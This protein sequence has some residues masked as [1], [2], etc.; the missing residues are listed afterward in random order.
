M[1][2]PI[3]E[4]MLAVSNSLAA[5]I[6]VK[7]TLIAALGLLGAWAA[8]SGRASVRHALLAASFGVLLALPLAAVFAP[9][10]R[11]AVTPAA[12]DR[13]LP[14]FAGATKAIPSAAA[15]PNG[16]AVKPAIRASQGLSPSAVLFM[17]WAAGTLLFLLP[18]MMGLWQVGALRRSALPWRHGQSLA[19]N[20]ARDAGIRRRVEVLLHESLPGPM[21]C[22]ILGPAIVLSQDAQ[23]WDEEDLNRAIVHE[24][25]HVRRGDW[26]ILC[27]ARAVCAAYWFHPLV[28]IAWRRL[29]LDAERACDDAVLGHSDAAAYADQLVGLARRLSAAAKPPLLAMANRAD[30]TARVHSVL[31]GGRQRGRAGMLAIAFTYAAALALVIAISPLRVVAATPP[32]DMAAQAASLTQFSA[33]GNLVIED[34]TVKDQNGK[35]IDG[36]TSN[37]FALTEDGVP[38]T[39]SIFEFQTLAASAQAGQ[40]SV[41]SYYILGYYPTN[42]E[43]DGKYRRVTVKNSDPIARLDYRP[44]Y[45]AAKRFVSATGTTSNDTGASPNVESDPNAP[46]AVYRKQPEY[47]EDARKAKFQGHVVLAVEV[48]ASGNVA[49]AK[50]IHHLG[51]GLDEKALEAIQQWKFKPG[52]KN[53]RPVAMEVEVTM[54]FRL[55]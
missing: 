23:T 26:V 21:T 22:G 20:L 41:Q 30:L 8:R 13:T 5:S 33:N 47:S 29:V 53:G 35:S 54:S 3:D 31:D 24:L 25:E 17:L 2:A 49:D 48:D 42:Q 52:T 1:M 37:D 46:V 7:A 43:T 12:H 10:V 16:T 18:V 9:P 38:Q 40:N 39:I 32:A 50:V 28:W 11:I 34:V 36:L 15:I 19:E 51:L 14:D 27:V 6:V 44:G 45:Y 4:V 55:L